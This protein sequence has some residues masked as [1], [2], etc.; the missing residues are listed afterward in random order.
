MKTKTYVVRGW[1]KFAEED[2]YSEGCKAENC[3]NASG[4]DSFNSENLDDLIKKLMVFVGTDNKEDVLLNSCDE[5]GR[6]DIQQ[7][8]ND[9]GY[10]A[11]EGQL[12]KWKEGK[13]K[14]WLA[15]YTFNIEEVKDVDLSVLNGL[16]YSEN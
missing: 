9:E 3:V 8:E 15:C 6:V 12:K 14:L 4:N 5:I 1:S 16:G 7:M 13:A 10:T 11:T 2:V